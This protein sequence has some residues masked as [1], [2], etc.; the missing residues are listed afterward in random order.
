MKRILSI[1][2]ILTLLIIPSQSVS[3]APE[4]EYYSIPV[5][6]SDHTGTIEH[7]DVM[8]R[9]RN[10]YVRADAIAERFG[11]DYTQKGDGIVFSNQNRDSIV[12]LG[13][14]KFTNNSTEVT[15]TLFTQFVDSYEAPF[16]S[17]INSQGA[18]IPF[19]YSLLLMNSGM[20]VLEDALLIDVPDKRI[21]DC[22]YDIA[23]NCGDYGFDFDKDF[24]YSNVDITGLTATSHVVNLFSG[25]LDFDKNSWLALAEQC[26]GSSRTYDRKFGEKLAV[27][28][29]TESDKE[30]D[31]TIKQMDTYVDLFSADG[32]LGQFLQ[33][34]KQLLDQNVGN[35]AQHCNDVLKSVS[36]GNTPLSH[37][38]RS[39]Q[40]LEKA[41]NQQTWLSDAGDT[42]IES[43]KALSG[44]AQFLEA[45]SLI[46]E[47]ASYTQ[48]FNNQD[49]FSV[50]ALTRYLQGEDTES[51]S[52]KSAMLNYVERLS[53]SLADFTASKFTENIYKHLISGPPIGEPGGS[54]IH[55]LLGSEASLIL[56]AWNLSSQVIPFISNG[57][58]SADCF[59]LALYSTVLQSDAFNK[60]RNYRDE[61]LSEPENLT[62]DELYE[63]S[64]LSYI[65]L[66]SCYITREAAIASLANK[67]EAVKR[68][69]RSLI[70][71]QNDINR[72]IARLMVTFKR[73]NRTNEGYVYGFLPVDN[74]KY[75]KVYSDDKLIEW[76]ENQTASWTN[77]EQHE[78]NQFLSSF[79]LFQLLTFKWFAW[80]L[81]TDSISTFEMVNFAVSILP[82]PL[83]S[84]QYFYFGLS[85]I[86]DVLDSYFDI[87]LSDDDMQKC[88]SNDPKKARNANVFNEMIYYEDGTLY[89]PAYS[90][91][92]GFYPAI[93]DV[94]VKNIDGSL[95]VYFDVYGYGEYDEYLSE[96]AIVDEILHLSR[97][98]AREYSDKLRFLHSGKAVIKMTP[99]GYKM[100]SSVYPV[101]DYEIADAGIPGHRPLSHIGFQRSFEHSA[102][103]G[104]SDINMIYA[105]PVETDGYAFSYQ[106]DFDG[107]GDDEI[108]IG[109]VEAESQSRHG[110]RPIIFEMRDGEWTESA[111]YMLPDGE[112]PIRLD[113]TAEHDIYFFVKKRTNGLDIFIEKWEDA[114][115]AT[116]HGWSLCQI[117]YDGTSMSGMIDGT[118]IG[119]EG[120]SDT[121]PYSL[122]SP[123]LAREWY[124]DEEFARDVELF[125]DKLNATGL[126][127]TEELSTVPL[128]LQDKSTELIID[129]RTRYTYDFEKE[130]EFLENP[131]AEPYQC[132]YTEFLFTNNLQNENEW[133]FHD[134]D[135]RYISEMEL[136][137]LSDFRLQTAINEIYA[138]HGYLFNDSEILSYFQSLS[139]YHGT[140]SSSDFSF[141]VFNEYEVVNLKLM[142]E[143][144]TQ[145]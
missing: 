10:V 142:Q 36:A 105:T 130:R 11:F 41:L 14:I 61:I 122:R 72:D 136:Y 44:A 17:V 29:C 92:L 25:I 37:Y 120:S 90:R 102:E 8:V 49:S 125:V 48:E 27:L 126:D 113:G 64:I 71:E 112:Y 69:I 124:D 2:L 7:L 137:G 40:A 109:Q 24:G 58:E 144:R 38:N 51:D 134:S 30:L 103:D 104:Y 65:Y 74:E 26:W 140:V 15:R 16:E 115:I 133:V 121:E 6:Y 101:D 28:L 145:P 138:R 118:W 42:I 31:A 3:A 33:D 80:E 56:L 93:A 62:A 12:P 86:N 52:A 60:F 22:L 106:G 111:D 78:L 67:P 127:V 100:V 47:I 85:E 114:T 99:Q 84:S 128:Y 76:I 87:I 35:L 95:T 129:I 82:V 117:R 108:L 9:G 13:L 139:W 32:V 83:D 45:A 18:W 96:D 66:K 50:E 94:P 131:S 97:K 132:L 141:S 5:E 70:D 75:L 68:E 107:D 119:Y 88:F 135:S 46:M 57:L 91:E 77:E 1:I 43:Q 54:L 4:E 116:G 81:D 143:M 79:T 53:G 20:M 98:E 73:A 89:I 19:E 23:D 21:L 63:M 55:D 39:Y 34:Q 59:E 110:I 123:D